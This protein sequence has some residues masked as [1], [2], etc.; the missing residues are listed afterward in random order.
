MKTHFLSA[1]LVFT[2]IGL[3]PIPVHAQVANKPPNTVAG[4]AV[5]YNEELVGTYSLPD[6]LELANNQKV[7][8]AATWNKQRRPEI[9]TWFEQN[10]Y[11]RAPERPRKLRFEVFDKGTPAFNGKATRKQITVYF[12]ERN[13]G[14]KMDLLVY[15]PANATKPV[16][17][18]LNINF[19]ANSSLVDDPGVRPGQVWNKE[20]QKVPAPAYNPAG[21]MKLTVEPFLTQGIAV[22]SVYYGDIEPDFNS[23]ISYGV[24]SLYLEPGQTQVA[25]N[26]WGTVAAWSWGLSRALD[27]FEKDKAIDSKRVALLGASRLGKTVLWAGAND[28]RFALVIASVSGEGGAAL[29]RRNYG[30]TIAHLVAPTRYAYQFCQNYQQLANKT[31]AP[32][33]SHMLVALLAPRPLLLQTGNTDYWSDPKG[34]FL[35]AVAATP[36][37]NLLGQQ[38]IE[39]N[40][41]PAASQKVGGTLSY[42]MHDGGHGILPSDYP[43][44]AEFMRTHLL[45]RK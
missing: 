25:P 41:L 23:G 32:M 30:E 45:Q 6:P 44:F 7:T 29:A 26:E 8:D 42:Y 11:G 19:L 35:A 12:S 43:V 34:E 31:D 5:N 15:L 2:G 22:A 4:I 36:V 27:Y 24:R 16:P 28:P 18:L 3:L 40:T 21:P 20:K 10:V 13:D 33:D 1:L 9:R 37:Y 17:L 38:G 39:T 14:P